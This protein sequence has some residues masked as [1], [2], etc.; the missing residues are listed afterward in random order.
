ME[1][2]IAQRKMGMLSPEEGEN[3]G[4]KPDGHYAIPRPPILLFALG[5]FEKDLPL[6]CGEGILC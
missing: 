5:G 6:M 2:V 3:G 1:E 4:R